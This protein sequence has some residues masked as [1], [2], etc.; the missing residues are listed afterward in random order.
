LQFGAVSRVGLPDSAEV[1]LTL[2]VSSAAARVGATG[3]RN[4][5]IST[6]RRTMQS[7]NAL[8]HPL[9]LRNSVMQEN[10]ALADAKFNK[11][12]CAP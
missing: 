4:Q 1:E 11:L 3:R 6:M 8:R 12:R 10:R 9:A 7:T 2:T 5:Q